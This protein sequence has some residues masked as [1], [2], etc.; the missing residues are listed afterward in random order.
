MA[1]CIVF[2]VAFQLSGYVP[3]T[4]L[5][6]YLQKAYRMP[7]SKSTFP[8]FNIGAIGIKC[9]VT[10]AAITA[11]STGVQPGI[12]SFNIAVK[13]D[14][15]PEGINENK[16]HANWFHT[17]KL[18]PNSIRVPVCNL[19][20]MI[21][22]SVPSSGNFQAEHG[23]SIELK[24]TNCELPLFNLTMISQEAV[25]A[26]H[27][28]PT[29]SLSLLGGTILN[30]VKIDAS[31]AVTQI[32]ASHVKHLDITADSGWADIDIKTINEKLYPVV[33]KTNK[34]SEICAKSPYLT[35]TNDQRKYIFD[36]PTTCV[37]D[38][39]EPCR[40]RVYGWPGN[41]CDNVTKCSSINDRCCGKSYLSGDGIVQEFCG[42]YSSKYNTDWINI[43]G[44][45]NADFIRVIT[46]GCIIEVATEREGVGT[47][48]TYGDF[49]PVCKDLGCDNVKSIRLF[50]NEETEENQKAELDSKSKFSSSFDCRNKCLST[51][52]GKRRNVKRKSIN[53]I[54]V[55]KNIGEMCWHACN[56]KQ[57]ACPWCG[58]GFCCRNGWW[59]K[60]GGCDGTMGEPGY[61]EHVC[62]A[63]PV[64]T[65][66]TV[67]VQHAGDMC[68]A[69]CDPST[70]R[71]GACPWCGDGYCCRNGWWDTAG[72]CDKILGTPGYEQHVCVAPPAEIILLENLNQEDDSS[73]VWCDGHQ[74]KSCSACTNGNGESWCGGD[75]IWESD[76]CVNPIDLNT[77]STSKTTNTMVD[78]KYIVSTS[79]ST[80][81]SSS[82]SIDS[83]ACKHYTWQADGTCRMFDDTATLRPKLNTMVRDQMCGSVLDP[84][85]CSNENEM[86]S[87]CSGTVEFNDNHSRTF[88]EIRTPMLC[89]RQLFQE[90]QIHKEST[91]ALCICHPRQLPVETVQFNIVF[92]NN[93]AVYMRH[94]L[95][96]KHEASKLRFD[97]FNTISSSIFNLTLDDIVQKSDILDTKHPMLQLSQLALKV[98]YMSQTTFFAGDE[99]LLRFRPIF[100]A[101]ISATLLKSRIVESQLTFTKSPCMT[102]KEMTW[103]NPNGNKSYS[104]SCRNAIDTYGQ[105]LSQVKIAQYDQ[106]S[107]YLRKQLLLPLRTKENE[108]MK[109]SI[110]NRYIL[111][112]AE[113]SGKHMNNLH[114][115]VYNV[116]QQEFQGDPNLSFRAVDLLALGLSFGIVLFVRSKSV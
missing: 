62:A 70:N 78:P 64:E 58:S 98:P 60:S 11:K 101:V 83:T 18:D 48:K 45:K 80:S 95:E 82:F 71:Q 36:P 84:Y 8:P 20:L 17:F 53:P 16:N 30:N 21:D 69:N 115:W 100:F 61:E 114:A 94:G 31:I 34:K 56:G 116:Y 99:V 57:G 97:V 33:L 63:N 49:V 39:T 96:Q 9:Q 54:V 46:P 74:A 41:D 10:I 12:Y 25:N 91:D 44:C 29:I 15:S 89:S 77:T 14:F 43:D 47:R 85:I 32:I 111:A 92:R 112:A 107:E 51:T 4:D 108:F 24:A 13:N 1:Y 19:L 104:M 72:G 68:W 59:D 93:G 22:P 27:S 66:K 26:W 81:S 42:E 102:T 110:Y 40:A 7:I 87:N 35:V 52:A 79:S 3:T 113:H 75:C 76:K 86:C 5:D 109:E 2:F 103:C 106:M 88:V 65:R 6:V 55:L 90:S 50:H 28:E 38:G 37:F 73:H 67:D 105:S 23:G